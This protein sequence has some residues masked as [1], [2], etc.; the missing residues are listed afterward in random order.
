MTREMLKVRLGACSVKKGSA[1]KCK[2]R[3]TRR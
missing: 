3:Q 1:A 2:Q